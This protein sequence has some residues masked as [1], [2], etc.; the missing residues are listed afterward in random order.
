MADPS[1]TEKATAKRRQEARKKGNIAKSP[2]INTAV[3]L[4]VAVIA[5]KASGNI[6]YR[7]FS[8]MLEKYLLELSVTD[9]NMLNIS[10][11]F[12]EIGFHIL[13]VIVPVMLIFMFSAIISNLLQ[14]GFLFT[15]EPIK[16]SFSKLNMLKGF[17]KLFSKE[18]LVTLIKSLL[19]VGLI[20]YLA[21]ST[22]RDNLP[23]L[24]NFFYQDIENNMLILANIAWAIL[25][26]IAIVFI[27]IAG[28][29][30]FFQWYNR[31]QQLRMSKQEIK[32]EHKK[33]EGDP[34]IKSAIRR[35]QMEMARR[36]MMSEIPKSDVVVT[37][38]VHLAIVIKYNAQEMKAPKVTAKGMNKIAERIKE[39]AI[40][41]DIPIVENPP[42]ARALY[43][44]CE[45]DKEIPADLYSTVAEILTYVYKMSGK[46]FGI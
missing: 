16:P 11:I 23:V 21:F 12:I 34:L 44:A 27:I 26:K 38:P 4:L 24:V 45:V 13:I 6:L 33:S 18:A 40:E 20:G 7:Y 5:L 14:V 35:K 30:Y 28:L 29:D 22:V 2:E 32:D 42:V 1:K 3:T 19:K 31:E 41:N 25:L 36:R 8:Y 9:V 46:R 43:K 17:K 37:N 15:L 10:M 39:I